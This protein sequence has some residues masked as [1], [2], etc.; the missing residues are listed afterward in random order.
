[1]PKCLF[2]FNE[3]TSFDREE[4]IIPES[5]G[6][7]DLVLPFG[8]VCDSCNQYFGSKIEQKVLSQPPF[9]VERVAAAVKSKKGKYPSYCREDSKISMF[10]TGY[11]DSVF[12]LGDPSLIL[13]QRI[14]LPY[15]LGLG[16]PSNIL[17]LMLK[18]GIELL[19]L[20][21]SYNPYD[22]MFDMC[23][24]HARFGIPGIYWDLGYAIMSKTKFFE[25]EN[26]CEDNSLDKQTLY[27]YEMGQL[28]NGDIIFS[29]IYRRHI[30]ITSLTTTSLSI[31]ESYYKAYLHDV[32][33]LNIFK[34]KL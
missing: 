12:L 34:T 15:D 21:E 7:D 20:T 28:V 29:F 14:I 3:G 18:M 16:Q 13:Q 24:K 1:M 17:R 27:R 32:F 26:S 22:A 33:D 19:S 31:Y 11:T 8:L 4:H 2:C 9:V 10:S 23:R 5:L 25:I 6:N 30:F